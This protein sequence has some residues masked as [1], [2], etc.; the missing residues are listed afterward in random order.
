[1]YIVAGMTRSLGFSITTLLLAMLS[2]QIGASYGKQLFPMVGPAGATALRLLFASIILLIIFRPWKGTYDRKQ[3]KAII[4]YGVSLGV[5]NLL[6]Y[7]ALARI[8]LGVAVAL[9]FTG[10]LTLAL[11]FSRRALDIAWV[12]LAVLGIALIVPSFDQTNVQIDGILLALGAGACWASYI[13]FGKK[14]AAGGHSNKVV[15]LGMIIAAIVVM[16]VGFVASSG[17]VE[18]FDA[19]PLAIWVA[20][21]SSAIP[22]SL[23]M[24]SL[25]TMPTT[26]FGVFMSFEPVVAALVGFAFLQEHLQ[27]TQWLAIGLIVLASA[28][29]ALK[30]SSE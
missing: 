11:I 3:L 4:A 6:F 5:M 29:S 27:W 24:V 22:Y 8:P 17:S 1:V 15:A 25:K 19:W 18:N 14:A 30:T 9:E 28:G 26:T 23:E 20:L 16:P 2:I 12:T 10:P 7:L 21:L 13:Y